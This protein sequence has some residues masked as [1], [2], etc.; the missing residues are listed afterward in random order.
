M[1]ESPTGD[2]SVVERCFAL[3]A[4]KQF[5]EVVTLGE[6]GLVARKS[7]NAQAPS[8]AAAQELTRLWGVVGLAKQNLADVEGARF[9]F[10]EA[11]ALAPQTERRT[12]ERNLAALALTTA[13]QSLDGGGAAD[14]SRPERIESIRSA[15]DWL[16]RGLAVAPDDED[17]R[18]TLVAARDALW[19]THEEVVKAL[20]QRKD[21]AEARRRLD[22]IMKDP[23]CPPERQRAFRALWG[24]A[25]GREIGH[26]TAE[27]IRHMQSGR[28]DEAV[29]AL[30]LAESVMAQLSADALPVKR[31]Q[32]LERRLW[33]GYMKLGVNRVEAG[34]QEAAL[35]PLFQALAFEDIGAE[36]Q[37]ETR[38][39]L[40]RAL[41]EIVDARGV[42]IGALIDAGDSAAAAI[43]GDKLWS[44]LRGAVDQGLPQDHLSDA[45]AKVSAL[46][47]RIG[48][49]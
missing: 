11:I 19:L 1:R 27:A 36:R 16:E 17:L 35:S 15:I 23:E 37:E 42:D 29:A 5:A 46:F 24:V 18:D 10:E 12:W 31:R 26:A 38:A 28:E 32:E 41:E 30:A 6:E 47:H 13:R 7:A 34:A 44:L 43:Q 33:W 45:F 3:L 4:A 14:P 48:K 20:V 8:A 9:A 39:T 25:M 21:L 2:E 22:D 40:V 49:R